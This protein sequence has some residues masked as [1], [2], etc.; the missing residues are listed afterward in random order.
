MLEQHLQVSCQYEVVIYTDASFLQMFLWERYRA[1]PSKPLEFKAV[2][3]E[4]VIIDEEE[5][6][7]TSHYKPRGL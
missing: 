6:E 5:R 4:K 7:K 1:L 2:N 3:P